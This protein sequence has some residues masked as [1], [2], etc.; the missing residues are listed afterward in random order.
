M[1]FTGKILNSDA[2]LNSYKEIGSLDFM[3]GSDIKLVMMLFNSQEGLRYV[4]GEAAIITLFIPSN[5]SD[6]EKTATFLDSGDRSLIYVD[7]S[8][9][10]TEDLTGGNLTFSVDELG[11]G[12]IIH[13]GYASLALRRIT[14]G[15][16]C[17]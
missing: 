17:C 7:L 4:P 15:E 1:T 14:A 12:S 10:E 3:P 5:T 2:E 11:D 6:L 16:P 8:Q 9:A 13:R